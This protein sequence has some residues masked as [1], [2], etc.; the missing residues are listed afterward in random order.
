MPLNKEVKPNQLYEENR[1]KATAAPQPSILFSQK[2][3]HFCDQCSFMLLH[4]KHLE[5]I[6]S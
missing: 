1:V 6:I 3:K 4:F 5:K 2:I